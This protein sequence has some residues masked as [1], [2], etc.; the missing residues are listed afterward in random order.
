MSAVERRLTEADSRIALRDHIVQVAMQARLRYGL[1]ID[2]AA[3]LHMLDDRQ[4][5]R[6]PCGVRYDAAA[7]LPG[8]FAHAQPLGDRPADG[9]C[10][11]VHPA[12]EKQADLLPLV[13]AYHLVTI[14][15]GDIATSDEAEIFGAT[16]LGLEVEEYYEALCEIS[17]HL[18]Q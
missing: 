6:Y 2:A 1:Y 7:L 5:T 12:L 13:I 11:F 16:L 15:Y 8:E 9:Y 10:L 4:V 18:L 3:I 14:N 17:D